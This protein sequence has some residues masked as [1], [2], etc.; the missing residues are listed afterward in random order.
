LI[1]CPGPQMVF[2]VKRF[3]GLVFR[4]RNPMLLLAFCQMTVT[5]LAQLSDLASPI[6]A[7]VSIDL[8]V[9][10]LL[11]I[12]GPLAAGI[13]A[14]MVHETFGGLKFL[15]PRSKGNLIWSQFLIAFIPVSLGIGATWCA[16]QI[17]SLLGGYASEQYQSLY[18][19][20]WLSMAQCIAIGC[21]LGVL[22]ESRFIGLIAAS[23]TY[24]FTLVAIVKFPAHA[25]PLAGL[26]PIEVNTWVSLSAFGVAA[27]AFW[28][29]VSSIALIGIATLKVGS[30]N[31]KKFIVASVSFS[32]LAGFLAASVPL[33]SLNMKPW[34]S[35]NCAQASDR[36]VCVQP[37]YEFYRSYAADEVTRVV[38]KMGGFGNTWQVSHEPRGIGERIEFGIWEFH[39]D[40][41]AVSK[42]RLPDVIR[43]DIVE[44]NFICS[45]SDIRP[46]ANVFATLPFESYLLGRQGHFTQMI[47]EQNISEF[48]AA[49]KFLNSRTSNQIEFW[50]SGHYQAMRLCKLT[51]ADYRA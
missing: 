7:A 3:L 50:V 27:L 42:A 15:P 8:E 13:V 19:L 44:S 36:R 24:V 35:L 6:R 51:F 14:A 20:A 32:I 48:K 37:G 39:L 4:L 1:Q 49:M 40:Q 5:I 17:Q 46:M 23:F 41:V 21:A 45:K 47:P 28:Y 34:L 9:N 10:R 2:S 25:Q 30:Q 43:Q 33:T 16:G 31:A 12:F 26:F 29:G 11:P 22:I 38:Q 18:L